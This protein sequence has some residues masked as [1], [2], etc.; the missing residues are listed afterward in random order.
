MVGHGHHLIFDMV[1]SLVEDL[2]PSRIQ[3]SPRASGPTNSPIRRP[4]TAP[5]SLTSSPPHAAI[6]SKFPQSSAAICSNFPQF[7]LAV[8]SAFSILD[9]HLLRAFSLIEHY[10]FR[11]GFDDDF[12]PYSAAPD[13]W[14]LKL[15]DP[16]QRHRT[17][18][19]GIKGEADPGDCSEARALGGLKHRPVN[20]YIDF[21]WWGLSLKVEG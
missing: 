9:R 15:L 19:P 16:S 10:L 21:F 12:S 17:A 1:T 14:P 4:F 13:N 7:S 2:H 6:H 18:S 3:G 11:P 8:C 20:E 5:R